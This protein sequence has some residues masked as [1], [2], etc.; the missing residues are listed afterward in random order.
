MRTFTLQCTALNGSNKVGKLKGRFPGTTSPG[1]WS[2]VIG[3]AVCFL[4]GWCLDHE[5]R[6]RRVCDP[7]R[8][9]CFR[10]SIASNARRGVGGIRDYRRLVAGDDIVTA[11]AAWRF[12]VV[13]CDQGTEERR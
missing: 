11:A 9:A 13:A 7:A 5:A 3:Y 6:T 10:R 2:D 1:C 12:D 8:R 4:P